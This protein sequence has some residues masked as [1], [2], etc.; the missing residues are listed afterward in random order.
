MNTTPEKGGGGP[1]A[2]HTECH[3][4]CTI[5]GCRLCNS[6]GEGSPPESLEGSF[7]PDFFTPNKEILESFSDIDSEIINYLLFK[8]EM[9]LSKKNFRQTEKIFGEA[10][11]D[12]INI[13][14]EFVNAIWSQVLEEL[15]KERKID[16]SLLSVNKNFDKFEQ[17][18]KKSITRKIFRSNN[19][20]RKNCKKYKE[21]LQMRMH[22]MDFDS[23]PVPVESDLF[24]IVTNDDRGQYQEYM[25]KFRY[26]FQ[27]FES[28]F[29]PKITTFNTNVKEQLE[30]LAR[31][32]TEKYDVLI[33]KL[34]E[35]KARI[36]CFDGDHDADDG[37]ITLARSMLENWDESHNVSFPNDVYIPPLNVKRIHREMNEAINEME[38]L[39][40]EA[41][42]KFAPEEVKNFVWEEVDSQVLRGLQTSDSEILK[43]CVH[44][45]GKYVLLTLFDT[46]AGDIDRG[47]RKVYHYE[48]IPFSTYDFQIYGVNVR[49][50]SGSNQEYYIITQMKSARWGQDNSFFTVSRISGGGI[51]QKDAVE[52]VNARLENAGFLSSGIKA[53]NEDDEDDCESSSNSTSKITTKRFHLPVL[54]LR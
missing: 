53:R 3:T 12:C 33:K 14:T 43:N 10:T 37:I 31:R 40:T 15:K 47:S 21:Q 48:R 41:G 20:T 46:F 7:S 50:I 8:L 49:L 11:I 51:S 5:A 25:N 45:S 22:I 6:E 23:G 52:I 2:D 32:E 36:S 16:Y 1:N 9:Y 4:E 29:I 18:M 13:K 42:I 54:P 27:E 28:S 24:D 38:K 17:E 39:L 30:A 35:L 34:L 19:S 26:K 44:D